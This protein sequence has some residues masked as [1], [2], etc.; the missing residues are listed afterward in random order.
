MRTCDVNTLDINTEQHNGTF[1]L[2]I[3]ADISGEDFN[4]TTQE[5]IGGQYS[6]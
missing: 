5:M 1:H 3:G 2:L 6:R 4:Q